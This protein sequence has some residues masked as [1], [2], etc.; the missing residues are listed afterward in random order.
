MPRSKRGPAPQLF[1]ASSTEKLPVARALARRL[2]RARRLQVDARDW[3][4]GTFRPG[5]TTIEGLEHMLDE[6]QFAVIVL[7]PDDVA[8]IRKKRHAIP[9]DNVLFELGLFMGRLGRDR[10]YMLYESDKEP[11]RPSDLLGVTAATYPKPGRG[12]IDKAL[13]PACAAILERVAEIVGTEER[14]G[15]AERI[16]GTWWEEI[17]TRKGVEVS[18]F[19]ILPGKRPGTVRMEGDHYD[20][21]GQRIGHWESTAVELD[22]QDQQVIYAWEGS[23]PPLAGKD[24]Q[25]VRGFGTLSFYHAEGD[26]QEGEGEFLDIV[27][28]RLRTAKK[29]SVRLRRESRKPVI[30]KMRSRSDAKRGAAVKE[31]RD[32]WR[33]K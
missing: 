3:K 2:R 32:E 21:E 31:I 17:T 5:E 8:Y 10:C 18:F 27:R 25:T 4:K 6:A 1:V 30:N 11:K 23:H 16:A 24:A 22:E 20:G 26:F 29:K 12:G 13:A 9:R 28:N 33:K 14:E 15:F 19:S 7:T